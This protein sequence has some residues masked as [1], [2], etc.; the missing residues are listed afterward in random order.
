MDNDFEKIEPSTI[1]N[2]TFTIYSS[3]AMLAGIELD[4]F[5]HLSQRACTLYEL[6][7]KLS[8]KAD[9]LRILLFTLVGSKLLNYSNGY[10]SNT[11]ETDKFLV[12]GKPDYEGGGAYFYRAFWSACL[13]T[14]QSIKTGVPQAEIDYSKL[15]EKELFNKLGSIYECTLSAGIHLASRFEFSKYNNLL[16]IGGG[17]GGIAIGACKVN[18]HMR[19]TI[20]ELDEVVSIPGFYVDRENLSDRI[21]IKGINIVEKKPEGI[22]DVAVARSFFQVLSPEEAI[23]AIK[24]IGSV[25]SQG[26]YLYIL[27]RILDNNFIFPEKTV[28]FNLVFAN[29]YDFGQAYTENEYAC[30]LNEGGFRIIEVL[31]DFF[32]DGQ[33]VIVARKCTEL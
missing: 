12:K 3:F 30:W 6:G 11:L 21:L 20:V 16:D 15:S 32:S 25:M 13:Q 5:T 17:N 28:L 22:Y 14:A 29:I 9:K 31:H 8:V 24:N 10:F 26:S 33:S 4:I 1:M 23:N 7:E 2:Y 27:G 18:C 19:A